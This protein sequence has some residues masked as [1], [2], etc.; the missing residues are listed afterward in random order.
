MTTMQPMY[1]CRRDTPR[2]GYL[3]GGRVPQPDKV[4]ENQQTAATAQPHV[5]EHVLR[6]LLGVL[7]TQVVN[8][9]DGWPAVE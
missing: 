7:P 4:A 6:R 2:R 8:A 5:P 1:A 3:G 9:A